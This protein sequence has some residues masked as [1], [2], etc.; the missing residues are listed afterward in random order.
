MTYKALGSRSIANYAA[1]VW[2]TKASESNIGKIE[3]AKNEAFRIVTG[4]H[5][6][7]SIK[8]LHS[9]TEILQVE[10]HIHLLSEQYLV[11]CL[12]T[13]NVC[14]HITMLYHPPQEIK[15]TLFIRHNHYRCWQSPRKIHS[16][17]FT[18]HLSIPQ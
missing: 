4:S 16:M 18:P 15:V 1:P 9:E 17:Q 6:M 10:D 12:D 2:S 5:K 3:R 8:H 14:H 7:S 11:H 13:G